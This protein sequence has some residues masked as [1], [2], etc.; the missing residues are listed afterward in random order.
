MSQYELTAMLNDLKFKLRMHLEERPT[1]AVNTG[2]VGYLERN[3]EEINAR[4]K[5][6]SKV[7]A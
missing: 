3:I 6:M 4:L 2:Y 5:T 1:H 7:A